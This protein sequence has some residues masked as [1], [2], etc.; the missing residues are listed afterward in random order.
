MHFFSRITIRDRALFYEH[1]SNLVE[2]GVTVTKAVKTF[3]A[4]GGNPLFVAELEQ[5]L[6]FIESGDSF[7]TSMKKLPRVF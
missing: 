1:I 5:L 3:V 7:S 2:G 6:T 4:K